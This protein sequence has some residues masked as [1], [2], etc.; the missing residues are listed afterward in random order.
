MGNYTSYLIIPEKKLIITNFQGS[1]TMNDLIQLNLLFISDNSYDSTFDLLMDFRESTALAFKMEIADFFD[2]FKK[3][4]S[5]KKKIHSGILFSTPN[6]NFLISV[7]KPPAMLMNIEAEGFREI[8]KCLEWMRFSVE[9]QVIIIE[10]LNSIKSK[11]T[12]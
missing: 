2:F 6:L 8:N 11:P 9:D 5:L 1:I 10:A 7:Y 3:N 4:I 12:D